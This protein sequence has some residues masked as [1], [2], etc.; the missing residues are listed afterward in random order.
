VTARGIGGVTDHQHALLERL[1]RHFTATDFVDRV[2]VAE[3]R[4]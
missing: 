3:E 4:A 2:P 1:I